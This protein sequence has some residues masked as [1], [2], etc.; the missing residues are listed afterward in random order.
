MPF[1]PSPPTF[2]ETIGF[3]TYHFTVCYIKLGFNCLL[4]YSINN[5][6]VG[7]GE[8]MGNIDNQV[9]HKLVLMQEKLGQLS[10]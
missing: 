5:T 7:G 2:H 8:G 9:G 3:G 1:Y 4:Y 6:A 10:Q